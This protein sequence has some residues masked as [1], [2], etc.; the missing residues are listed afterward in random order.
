M[1][2]Y[3]AL[4]ILK[5]LSLKMKLRKKF[6]TSITDAI[7]CNAIASFVAHFADSNRSHFLVICEHDNYTVKNKVNILTL[8]RVFFF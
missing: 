8:Q 5:C 4:H 7:L 3:L 1:Q 2:S 6:K